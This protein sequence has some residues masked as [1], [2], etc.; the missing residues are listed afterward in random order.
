MKKIIKTEDIIEYILSSKASVVPIKILEGLKEEIEKIEE[1]D[2]NY[3]VGSVDTKDIDLIVDKN[4]HIEYH[5]PNEES[6]IIKKLKDKGTKFYFDTLRENRLFSIPENIIKIID[7]YLW[8]TK[9]S[10]I[11]V[12]ADN[13]ILYL[14]LRVKRLDLN[15]FTEIKN[16]IERDTNCCI[17][18]DEHNRNIFRHFSRSIGFWL[19]GP[20][21]CWKVLHRRPNVQDE[22]KYFLEGIIDNIILPKAR[23]VADEYLIESMCCNNF[24]S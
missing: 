8:A 15:T 23:V 9:S 12:D 21:K 16:K 4:H 11:F 3:L 6:K 5:N 19:V 20:G 7:G 18:F 13:L 22:A 14:M 17:C 2:T 24:L 10:R 1:R